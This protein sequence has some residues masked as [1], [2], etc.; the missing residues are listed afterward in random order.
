[1]KVYLFNSEKHRNMYGFTPD[2]TGGNLPKEFGPWS[3][4]KELD[5]NPGE[6]PRAGVKTEDILDGIK[7]DGFHLA[8]VEIKVTEAIVPD[9]PPKKI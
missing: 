2:Q 1:M 3:K 9:L 4:F 5:V 8:R 7:R 6:P